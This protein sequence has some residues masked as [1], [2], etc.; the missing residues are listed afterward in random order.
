LKIYCFHFF[1]TRFT[2]QER[3]TYIDPD[4]SHTL[5]VREQQLSHKQKYISYVT[6]KAA[7]RKSN[8]LARYI[9]LWLTGVWKLNACEYRW[10]FHN[11]SLSNSIEVA[12]PPG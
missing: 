6:S 4:Y 3:Y 10:S 5:D 12:G 1:R 11:I 2:G 9:M 8:K 7:Q